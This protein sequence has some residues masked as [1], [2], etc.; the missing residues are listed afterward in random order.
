MGMRFV[1]IHMIYTGSIDEYKL[2]KSN[3][4]RKV[5]ESNLSVA[6]KQMGH[7]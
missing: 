6:V 3:I 5:E 4:M 7:S 1:Y 2:H